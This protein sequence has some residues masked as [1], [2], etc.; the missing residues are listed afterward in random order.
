MP[1][2]VPFNCIIII[3]IIILTSQLVPLNGIKPI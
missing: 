1:Q 2:L 3:I